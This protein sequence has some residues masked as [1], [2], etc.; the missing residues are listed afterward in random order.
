MPHRIGITGH[1]EFDPATS[2]LIRATLRRMIE[3]YQPDDLIGVSCLAEGADTMFAEAV[4]DRGGRLEVVVPAVRYREALPASHQPAYD[5]CLARA[6]AVHRLAL[7]E[8]D[9]TAYLA[10]NER[11]LAAVDRL[12]AVWD[13]L[14]ARGPGGTADVVAEARRRGMPVEVV[15]PTGARRA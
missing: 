9:N 14:P 6:T 1:R 5:A 15:W 10:G 11:M 8:S 3:A 12:I 13:G 2:L 4:A 7:V